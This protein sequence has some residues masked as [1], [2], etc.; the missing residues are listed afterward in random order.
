M[1]NRSL[2]IIVERDC[3]KSPR[4]T[5][6][7]RSIS[8]W[9]QRSTVPG[10]SEYCQ[11][12]IIGYALVEKYARIGDPFH[13]DY[14]EL[15]D[16]LEQEAVDYWLKPENNINPDPLTETRSA[17]MLIHRNCGRDWYGAYPFLGTYDFSSNEEIIGMAEVEPNMT[18]PSGAALSDMKTWLQNSAY[19]VYFDIEFNH[20]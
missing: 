19:D 4:T 18:V 5:G 3:S 1:S 17:R 6:Y 20:E 10:S 2:R 16:Q 15:V 8:L 7:D 13:D 14:N 9:S 12:Y 11:T